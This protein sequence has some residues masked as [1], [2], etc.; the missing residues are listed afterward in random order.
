MKSRGPQGDLPGWF[1]DVEQAALSTRIDRRLPLVDRCRD[2]MEME[3]AGQ[4][5][6]TGA[7]AEDRDRLSHGCAPA[8]A[9]DRR[10]QRPVTTVARDH[11]AI[12]S[13]TLADPCEERG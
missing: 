3:D 1:V 7:R 4:H 11:R 2:P 10:L 9:C 8:T 13:E 12:A 6:A 5:E